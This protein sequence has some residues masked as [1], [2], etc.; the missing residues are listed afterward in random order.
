M[1]GGDFGIVDD[2]FA[3]LANAVA[4]VDIFSVKEVALVP[5]ANFVEKFFGE[6]DVGTSGHI[7]GV[8]PIIAFV[9]LV[10][11]VKET[12]IGKEGI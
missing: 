7:D 9:T 1:D 4:E 6:H 3:G 11:V 12:T 5:T 2:F 8:N 10:V